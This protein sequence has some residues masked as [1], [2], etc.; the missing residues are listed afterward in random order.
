MSKNNGLLSSTI[1]RK[2]AMA[3]SALFLIIFVTQHLFINILSVIN[4][5]A[6]NAVSHFM[7]YNPL[8]QMVIQPI[9]IIGILFHFIMG[10]VLEI[11]NKNA[12]GNQAYV[13]TKN[14]GSSSW[15]SRNMIISGA[16]ILFFLAIHMVDFFFPEMN[17]KYIQSTPEDPTRYYPELVHHFQNPIRVFL[18]LIGF[19]F[20]GLHLNHGFQSAFQSMGANHSKYTP[21]IKS[22]GNIYSIIVPALFSFIVLY[23]YFN[24]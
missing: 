16:F 21:K 9:L 7:G 8:V 2:F 1:G 20:L 5:N 14:G 11:Q 17:Y 3:I 10:F 22:A 6:F 4:P 19:V 18:Y 24:S 12:R 13:Y 15:V 23:H